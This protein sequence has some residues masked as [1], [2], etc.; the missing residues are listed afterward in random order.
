MRGPFKG[1]YKGY[2][3]VLDLGFGGGLGLKVMGLGYRVERLGFR[4][5]G[6]ALNSGR[7]T[8]ENKGFLF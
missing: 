6:L 3:G 5:Y 2:Q 4:I 1:S 8:A 7:A